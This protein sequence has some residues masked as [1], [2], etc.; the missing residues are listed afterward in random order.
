TKEVLGDYKT[1]PHFSPQRRQE[2]MIH[3]LLKNEE[4]PFFEFCSQEFNI[5]RTTIYHDLQK[6]NEHLTEYDLNLEKN[7]N[8]RMISGREINIRILMVTNIFNMLSQKNKED[9][10]YLLD[11][12]ESIITSD[13]KIL[14]PFAPSL[15]LQEIRQAIKMIEDNAQLFFTFQSQLYLTL[16]IAVSIKRIK[17]GN[18]VK[19]TNKNSIIDKYQQD[20][21]LARSISQTIAE[22]F[23]TEIPEDEIIGGLLLTW[24]NVDYDKRFNNKEY[25]KEKV[26]SSIIKTA[27]RIINEFR[28]SL[29]SNLEDNSTLFIGLIL[30]L[31]R[32]HI[33]AAHDIIISSRDFEEIQN[34]TVISSLVNKDDVKKINDKIKII[35]ELRNYF[36]LQ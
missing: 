1:E 25:I 33:R 7:S 29:S 6:I 30:Y 26:D 2:K 36:S 4:K 9:I 23:N 27:D 24:C 35:H 14:K 10:I 8:Q 31:R 15:D 5:S 19:I 20:Y 28:Q 22:K 21:Q 32:I 3:F 13:H 18:M 12:G 11:Q 16:Y 17:A 34:L